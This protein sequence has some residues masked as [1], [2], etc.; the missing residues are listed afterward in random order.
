V[1]LNLDD[2]K[3]VVGDYIHHYNNVRLNSAIGYIAPIDKLNGRSE[4]IFRARDLKLELARQTRK[5]KRSG[6][7][8][9]NNIM[10]A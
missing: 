7:V 2:A 8:R 4:E 10:S 5:E 9:K 3:R 1:L 6:K